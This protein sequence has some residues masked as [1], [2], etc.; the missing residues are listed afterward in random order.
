MLVGRRRRCGNRWR[1]LGLERLLRD[2]AALDPPRARLVARERQDQVRAAFP[3][4]DVRDVRPRR[5]RLR[6]RVR[7]EDGELVALVLEE[8]VGGSAGLELEA[9]RARERVPARE[10]ALGDAVAE[11]DQAAGLVRRL[12]LRVLLERAP[13]GARDYHQMVRSSSSPPRA[14]SQ[15]DAEMYF[16][17]PSARTHTTTPSSISAASLRA[18]WTAAPDETPAKRPSRCSSTCTAAT[19]SS[20]ETSTF[21][22]SFETSRIGGV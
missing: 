16:Q 6:L 11:S 14:S 5:A 13:H 3:Q 18:T 22:S 17:P 19:A 2:C 7:V 21:R 20:F 12:R 10:I 8:E 9:V 4:A 15:N 1:L